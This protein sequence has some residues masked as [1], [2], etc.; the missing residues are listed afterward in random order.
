MGQ[1]WSI[2]VTGLYSPFTGSR[3]ATGHLSDSTPKGPP[4]ERP[5]DFMFM[6]VDALVWPAIHVEIEVVALVPA[7]G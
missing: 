3:S 1:S 2:C 5:R 7:Q 6:V 4:D